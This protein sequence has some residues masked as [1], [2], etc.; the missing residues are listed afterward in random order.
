MSLPAKLSATVVRISCDVPRETYGPLLALAQRV[1]FLMGD[2]EPVFQTARQQVFELTRRVL[3]EASSA[4][5]ALG[6]IVHE[7][8]RL[9]KGPACIVLDSVDAADEA[10][11][12]AL[13]QILE[14]PGW[15][16]VPLV[17]GWKS[18]EPTGLALEVLNALTKTEGDEAVLHAPAQPPP[19]SFST[20]ALPSDARF[21]MRAASVVGPAFELPLLCDLVGQSPLEVLL[22]LQVARDAG[23]PIEDRGDGTFA[24]DAGHAQLLQA[25]LLPSLRAVLHRRAAELLSP[26]PSSIEEHA[27]KPSLDAGGL[28]SELFDTATVEPAASTPD[29]P[30]AVVATPVVDTVAPVPSANQATTALSAGIGAAPGRGAPRPTADN[31]ARA[32]EHLFESGDF[33]QAAERALLAAIKAASLGGYAQAEGF[34]RRALEAAIGLPDSE[35]SRRLR[36]RA[37]IQLG[38]LRLE[39][40]APTATFDLTSALQPLEAAKRSLS[41]EDSPDQHAELAQLLAAVHCERGDGESLDKA[42]A[43]MADTSREL[44]E[45]GHAVQAA[46]LLNDQAA[47]Y[48]KMGDPVRAVALLE[49]SREVFEHR[50]PNDPVTVRELA[51]TNHLLARILLRVPPKPGREADALSSG[52][53]HAMAAGRAYERLGDAHSRGRVLETLGRIELARGKVDVALTRLQTALDEQQRILDLVGLART[54]A[55]MSDALLAAGKTEEAAGLLAD[56]V[57]LNHQK[58]SAVGIGFNRRAFQALEHELEKRTTGERAEFMAIVEEIRGRLAAAENELGVRNS[59]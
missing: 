11:L 48:M 45:R 41:A 30:P 13:K 6:Q 22:H 27:A 17:L 12:D 42:L 55:A 34:A 14:R 56:S 53:D 47:V 9:A 31:P 29:A 49:Q 59:D 20:S 51:E 21:V 38:R 54:T 8:N 40:Y 46:R 7:A 52:V 4:K 15:L 23:L 5:V 37:L 25:S 44:L 28:P 2:A 58:G 3:G 19:S 43:E 33:A 10:S 57:A 32:S 35:A 36:T 26:A 50:P 16:K 18:A 1:R 24:L 39:G